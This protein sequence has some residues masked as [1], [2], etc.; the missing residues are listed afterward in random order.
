MVIKSLFLIDAIMLN[1]KLLYY[2]N[3]KKIKENLKNSLS[4]KIKREDFSFNKK[5]TT[6]KLLVI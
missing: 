5:T 2:E 1:F 3:S 6:M 4:N